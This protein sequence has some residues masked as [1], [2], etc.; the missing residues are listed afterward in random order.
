[1]TDRPST[2][3]IRGDMSSPTPSY[4]EQIAP[5]TG[6]VVAPRSHLDTDTTTVDLTGRWD[7]RL[8]AGADADLPSIEELTGTG[9]STAGEGWD[10]IEVPAHWVLQGSGRWGRP[11]YTNIRYPFPV[12]PPHVPDENPTA[13]Y[14]RQFRVPATMLTEGR[15]LLR[16]DGIESLGRV[17]VNGT[18]LGLVRGS[19]LR[20]ELDVTDQLRDGEN[21]LVVRVH[22]W[23][24]MTYVEDQD[25]WWLPGIFRDVSLVHRPA[26]GLDD[27]WLRADRDPSTGRGSLEVHL[28]CADSAY[29]VRVSCPELD[30]EVELETPADRHELEVG[31][32]EPWSADRPR[33]YEVIVSTAVESVRVRTG[34]RRVE[35]VGDSW[36]VNGRR[37]RIR[38]VNRHDFH[39][40][41]G[42]VFDREQA[43]ADLLLMKRS[44]INAIRT[45]HYPPHPSLL[46][47]AD[48]IGL[49]VIEECDLETHG[50][51]PVGWVHNP[52][53]DVVWR[54]VY[55]DR[56]ERMVERDKNHPSVIAWSLGNESGSGANLAAMAAWVRRRDPSRPVL[57]EGD[58]E[59]THVDVVTRMY[60]PVEELE[61]LVQERRAP[62]VL[63]E[64]LHAMG[65]GAGGVA[66]YERMI[67]AHPA[68]HGGLVWEWRDHGLL[69]E[70]DDGTIY[71][72]YGGDF[73]E[74]M[75][76][77]SFVCD[78]LLLADSTPTPMLAELAAVFS[79]VKI[80]VGDDGV[81]LT[82]HRH[83][84]STDDLALGWVHEVD[85]L[86]VAAGTLDLPVAG[87][88]ES[89]HGQLPPLDLADAGEHWLTVTAALTRP[90]TWAP[91]GHVVA[92]TQ[93]HL[94]DVRQPEEP[95]RPAASVPPSVT[96]SGWDLGHARFDRAGRLLGLGGLELE[97]LGVVFWRAPT[98][99]DSHDDFGSYEI[100]PPSQTGGFGLPGPS[101]AARWQEAGLDRM[102]SRLV[103]VHDDGPALRTL[104]RYA[105][106]GSALAAF[107]QQGWTWR[108]GTLRLEVDVQPSGDW[109]RTWPRVGVHLRLPGGYTDVAWFGTGPLENYPDS[110]EAARVGRFA[111]SVDDLVVPYVVPQESGHR[112]ELR[113]LRISGA[114]LPTLTVAT[115]PVGGARPGFVLARH[116]AEE[117]TAAA[118][119]HELPA[120]TG[121]HLYLDLAQHGLGSRACGPDVQPEHA[122][123]PRPLSASICLRLE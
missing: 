59:D 96:R 94:G 83:D 42:R 104:R 79:P 88:G 73:G 30:L 13:D 98:E 50:F 10:S 38:G 52:S 32:V 31:D 87:P 110:R 65:N 16:F 112:S 122:L 90:T 84:G 12:D 26:G 80:H 121:T 27:V 74:E 70:T 11:I 48:E 105:P 43:R 101:S 45:S 57:Y 3:P 85:G 116:S 62:I 77:G 63:C 78:G 24:A 6:A 19:R 89:V 93:V 20:T 108:E 60:S 44:N 81:R 37:L 106:A 35:V 103:S 97:D 58:H 7:F 109:D 102:R 17:W 118:H 82:N 115:E 92:R 34:F 75:H 99:N 2:P 67:D 53:D 8:H 39:P 28:R 95:A 91:A 51:E 119:Q 14:R 23:S 69:T 114:G 18:E 66:H 54:D 100:G 111:S 22:Q 41:R 5:S 68:L 9:T 21:V 46:D 49:W 76:D 64:Y 33:L 113:E 56:A 1:M 107:V 71:H 40:E 4:V 86:E 61:R 25:Q 36:L 120:S 123:W 29:P 47:L 72:A 117:W 55:L 15:V